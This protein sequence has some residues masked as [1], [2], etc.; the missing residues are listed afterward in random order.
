MSARRHWFS[1]LTLAAFLFA[2]YAAPPQVAAQDPSPVSIIVDNTGDASAPDTGDYCTDAPNDC[3]LR[4][5]ITL[6]NTLG[7]NVT[8][9]ISFNTTV[10]GQILING[11]GAL[12]PL[13][14]GRINIIGRLSLGLPVVEIVGAGNSSN[15][16]YGFYINSDLNT[17]SNLAIYGFNSGMDTGGGSGIYITGDENRVLNSYIGTTPSGTPGGPTSITPNVR[18]IL[19]QG[20]DKNRIGCVQAVPGTLANVIANN[21]GI[22]I[23]LLNA[24]RN[25]ICGNYIGV[26]P[27]SATTVALPGN[28]SYGI[29]VSSSGGSSSS[30]NVIGGSVELEANII[31]GNGGAGIIISGSNTTG[32]QINGNYIGAYISGIDVGNVGDGVL[33][34]ASARDTT[35]SGTSQAR[36]L[37]SSNKGYGV[38]I[39]GTGTQNTVITGNTL[40]GLNFVG[41]GA[42]PNGLGGVR[43]ASGATGTVISGL[44]VR[45]AGNTDGIGVDLQ[46][47]SNHRVENAYIGIAPNPSNNALTISAGNAGGILVNGASNTTISG[48]RIAAN[49]EFGLRLNNAQNATIRSNFIGLDVN[50]TAAAG[51]AGPGIEIING[52]NILVGGADG[53]NYIAGNTGANGHGIDISGTTTLSVTVAGNTIGLARDAARGNSAAAYV[54]P[55]GNAGAGVRA[56][57]GGDLRIHE[58]TIAESGGAAISISDVPATTLPPGSTEPLTV[59]LRLNEIGFLPTN[60]DDVFTDVGNGQGIVLSN[61]R[62]FEVISNSVRYSA[63]PNL[64]LSATVTTTVD[65]LVAGNRFSNGGAEGVLVEGIARDVTLRDNEIR[66]NT[67]AA[68]RLAPTTRRITLDGNRMAGNGGAVVLEGTAAYPGTGADPQQ[69]NPGANRD[70]DPPQLLSAAQDGRITGRVFVP[71]NATPPTNELNLTPI[72]ACAR[73]PRPCTIQAFAADPTLLDGQG[74]RVLSFVEG[75]TLSVDAEGNFS[76]QLV[77]GL[78]SQLLLAATDGFGNTSAFTAFTPNYGLTLTPITPNP[79]VANAAP[80]ETVTYRLLLE[81]TGNVNYSDLTYVLSDTLT[82]VGGEQSTAWTAA[83]DPEPLP[84]LDAG[85]SRTLTVTVTLPAGTTL[86]GQPNPNAAPGVID[87]TRVTVR[88]TSIPTAT[89]NRVLETTVLARAVLRVDPRQNPLG[90]GAPNSR[91]TYQH[92]ITNDGNVPV[93]VNIDR[94]TVD[95]ADSGSVWVTTVSTNNF[96]LNPGQS[97]NLAVN[98]TVPENAQVTDGVGNPVR[99]TTLLTATV[100]GVPEATTTFSNTTGVVLRPAARFFSDEARTARAGATVTFIHELE[101]LSNGPATFRFNVTTNFD[102]QVTLASNTPGVQIVNNTVTLDAPNRTGP[103]RMQLR[104][105][106]RVDERRLP[107]DIEVVNIFLTD[108]ATSGAIGAG[109]VDTITI[110]E[111]FILPRLYLP[112]VAGPPAEATPQAPAPQEPAPEQ[113]RADGRPIYSGE[114]NA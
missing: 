31:G 48:V 9:N 13:E 54:V 15:R 100:A 62:A 43:S 107:S 3:S 84:L 87:R 111:G 47:G 34:E 51:N 110:T 26:R 33:I 5:A 63:G 108:S 95:P 78:P 61:A 40:I 37:L 12:P 90:F 97:Q 102:S 32:T 113:A 106:V 104:V 8:K 96:Q 41:D 66:A 65:H 80:T 2:P 92:R 18:G 103:S 27:T 69:A 19:I 72:S 60:D 17:I 67:G 4:Q 109:V 112:M 88:S 30:A 20:G 82:A 39:S 28:G 36:L 75:T 10:A 46:G 93:T 91:V 23:E 45:I 70:I 57:G 85:A 79:A 98:V 81:N 73:T 89:V 74:W 52:R 53:R 1:I 55:A 101:N 99:A 56:V 29:R 11:E 44:G 14:S 76:G 105:T 6:A 38:R 49:T 94:R 21:S 35:L 68:V 24:S 86:A 64:R 58:N 83:F 71:T 114:Q 42:Q 7:Q 77:G 59:S 25:T 22:G 50:R 16:G